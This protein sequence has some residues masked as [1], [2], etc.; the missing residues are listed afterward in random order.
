M[1]VAAAAGLAVRS[2]S[3]AVAAWLVVAQSV[4]I[5]VQSPLATVEHLVALSTGASMTLAISP[6]PALSRL[7]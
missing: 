6:R 3:V 1:V 5:L 2:R 4:G 7:G